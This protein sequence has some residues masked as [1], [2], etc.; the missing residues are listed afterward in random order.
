MFLNQKNVFGKCINSAGSA[1]KNYNTSA[2]ISEHAV[3]SGPYTG[4]YFHVSD[5]DITR[6]TANHEPG[7]FNLI[8]GF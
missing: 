7:V 2:V 5:P 6:K 3:F 4:K 8:S 1:G